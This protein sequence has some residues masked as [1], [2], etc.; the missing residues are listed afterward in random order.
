MEQVKAPGPMAGG[1]KA[2]APVDPTKAAA[3]AKK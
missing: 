3:P 2:T 1:E